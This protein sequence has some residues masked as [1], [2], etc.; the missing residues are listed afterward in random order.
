MRY[1]TLSLFILTTLWACSQ[2]AEDPVP[3]NSLRFL[4]KVYLHQGTRQQEGDYSI[5]EYKQTNSR[6]YFVSPNT[7]GNQYL[8]SVKYKSTFEELGL[9]VYSLGSEHIGYDDYS[10]VYIVPS[11]DELGLVVFLSVKTPDLPEKHENAEMIL[12]GLKNLK[13]FAEKPAS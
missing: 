13:Q 4:D 1:L 6:I 9:E 2:Q 12:S 8:F 7:E 11:E 5:T 3:S 10:I